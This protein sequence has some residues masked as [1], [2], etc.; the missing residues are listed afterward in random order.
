[1]FE[2]VYPFNLNY[3]LIINY[4]G[5]KEDKGRNTKILHLIYMIKKN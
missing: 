5:D 3:F 4:K 1:M 2:F